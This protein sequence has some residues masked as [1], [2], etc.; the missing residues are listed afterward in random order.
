MSEKRDE[1][2]LDTLAHWEEIRAKGSLKM[3]NA[4]KFFTFFS[5]TLMILLT[6]IFW[7]YEIKFT[8][9]TSTTAFD[10][11]VIMCLSVPIVL[12]LSKKFKYLIISLIIIIPFLYFIRKFDIS[13]LNYFFYGFFWGM[14][15]TSLL[16][17]IYES[18]YLLD[19]KEW[20]RHKFKKQMMREIIKDISP[21][22]VYEPHKFIEFNE[23]DIPQIYS[24]GVLDS[25]YGDDL[26]YGEID[27]VKIKFSDVKFSKIA[28]ALERQLIKNKVMFFGVLFIAEFNKSF[29][30]RVVVLDNY[31][32]FAKSNFPITSMDNMEFS[33]TFTTYCD[34]EIGARY[35]LTPV[36]MEKIL[37]LRKSLNTK[38]NFCFFNN[39]IYIYLNFN[40]DSFEKIDYH[41]PIIG[42]NSIA[43][44]YKKEIIQFIDIVK[45]LNLNSKVFKPNLEQNK[46]QN[47][48]VSQEFRKIYTEP[49]K[50]NLPQKKQ[51]VAEPKSDMFE[52]IFAFMFIGFFAILVSVIAGGF[53]GLLFFILFGICIGL[54]RYF[55]KPKQV[56]QND[57]RA[58]NAFRA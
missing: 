11:L 2:T 52:T 17:I 49:I 54:I 37:N 32:E 46:V 15:I 40:R 12:L 8:K 45:D 33:N 53:K 39:K 21:N 31:D 50:E 41:K 38:C 26:I 14:I 4:G 16:L 47:A 25:Y 20:F 3:K 18:I 5:P 42:E 48:F 6:Y 27:G 57:A 7:R 13:G 24:E 29:K 36:L 58:K 55:D 51:I 23:F 30:S 9:H 10:L 43:E 22:L 1:I 34:N 19:F 35:I 28:P 44:E 56:G